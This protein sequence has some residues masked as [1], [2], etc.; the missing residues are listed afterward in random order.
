MRLRNI[1][2]AGMILL[3]LAFTVGMAG[4]IENGTANETPT[5]NVTGTPTETLTVNVTA[6]PT[7]TLT[8]T[9]TATPEPDDDDE[10]DTGIF[11]PGHLLYRLK[12]AFE[13]MD[14]TFTYNSSEKLGKQVS[15]ARHRINEYRKAL[16]Q[17]DMEAADKALAQYEEKMNGVNASISEISDR[18]T[19]YINAKQMV[20]KHQLILENLSI[21]HPDNKGLQRAYKN[22]KKLEEK[23]RSKSVRV[24][25]EERDESEDAK[26]RTRIKAEVTDN[27][28][29][30]NIDLRFQVNS[31]NKT[32]IVEGTL[33]ELKNLRI[34][35]SENLKLEHDDD[36]TDVTGAPTTTL[37]ASDEKDSK[38]Y[39][40]KLHVKAKVEGNFT[41]VKVEFKFH[42]NETTKSGI[43]DGINKKLSELNS[44]EIVKGL[45]LKVLEH[46]K[47][48]NGNEIENSRDIE[49]SK[50]SE[51]SAKVEKKGKYET[52][53]GGSEKED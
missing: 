11:G 30:V 44:D 53:K 27:G 14:E 9:P 28:S 33:D 2:M 51:S 25:M 18:D 29:T 48:E 24:E 40:V 38:D 22:S 1:T 6:T 41:D 21:S 35:L 47:V 45:E 52:I 23:L 5:V 10:S 42:L 19:G 4:A 46:K 7:V 49:R 32:D 39:N 34:N 37:T 43:I 3:V 20:L 15:H 31:T 50:Q 17:N 12:I 36:S 26:E 16:K 8:V 13:N